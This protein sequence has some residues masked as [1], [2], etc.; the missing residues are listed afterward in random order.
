M[1][2]TIPAASKSAAALP[3][4][5]GFFFEHH[6]LVDL[7]VENPHGRLADEYLREMRFD[8]GVHVKTQ[9][10]PASDIHR[11]DIFVRLTAMAGL[12]PMFVVELDYRADV[13]LHRI[14]E[15]DEAQVLNVQVPE[16]LFPRLQKIFEAC[17]GFAGYPELR[18]QGLDFAG[19]FEQTRAAG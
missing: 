13:A 6:H 2:D 16:A 15:E 4:E 10:L 18:L 17:G 1:T 8:H 19:V 7:S 9:K 12:Q 3:D 5:P 11:V 14:S